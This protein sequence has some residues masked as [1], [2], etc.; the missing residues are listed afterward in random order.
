MRLVP[1]HRETLG[2]EL[3]CSGCSR[4]C[5]TRSPRPVRRWLR[6]LALPLVLTALS[7]CRPSLNY[8]DPS[9]PRYAG[10][11]ATASGEAGDAISIRVVSFNVQHAREADTAAALLEEHADLRGAD[12]ILLQ[13]MDAPAVRMIADALGVAYVYYPSFLHGGEGNDFGNA[14][15]SRWPIVADE[16]IVL[17]Y[18]GIVTRTQRIA[19]AATICVAGSPV[20]VYSTHLGTIAELVPRERRTQLRAVLVDAAGHEDVIIGGDMND[21][22]VGELA[23][24]A[25][26]DWPT[27]RG[28][29]T[30]A[31]GRWDHIFTRGFDGAGPAAGTVLDNRGSSDHLPVWTTL[32]LNTVGDDGGDRCGD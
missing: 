8:P 20:R 10:G 32:A 21:A 24:S 3:R 7:A 31:L 17:P 30:V 1:P 5:P 27:R 26:F 14:V 16:K 29:R 4:G 19:T 11:D 13:E 18:L 12:V 23:M 22:G 28:P 2:A 25:G 9:G 6:A 15:L